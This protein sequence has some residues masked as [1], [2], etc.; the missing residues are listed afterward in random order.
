MQKTLIFKSLKALKRV[1]THFEVVDLAGVFSE[2]SGVAGACTKATAAAV[3]N[4]Y[5]HLNNG[6]S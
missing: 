3:F 5:L 1:K 2:Q 4:L 6:R